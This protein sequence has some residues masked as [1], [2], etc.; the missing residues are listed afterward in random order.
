LEEQVRRVRNLEIGVLAFGYSAG[1]RSPLLR[2]V[3]VSVGL[4]CPG[5]GPTAINSMKAIAVCSAPMM[6]MQ[7]A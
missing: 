5:Y 4:Y 3:L 6:P 1:P 7:D 2:K